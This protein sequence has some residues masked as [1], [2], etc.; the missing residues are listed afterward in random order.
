[1]GIYIKDIKIPKN[2]GNC[3]FCNGIASTDYGLCTW[4]DVD[5]KVRD[6]Y[7]R[8]DCPF[9]PVPPHGRLIDADAILQKA[10][11]GEEPFDWIDKKELIELF[12]DAPTI[13][14]AESLKEE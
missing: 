12:F 3:H 6:V 14:P 13:I 8:Q 5:G 7:T 1:M 2:C 4:C 9:I 11:K 10:T